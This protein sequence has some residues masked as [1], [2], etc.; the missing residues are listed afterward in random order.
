MLGTIL[1]PG[2]SGSTAHLPSGAHVSVEKKGDGVMRALSKEQVTR[3]EQAEKARKERSSQGKD[4]RA[5]RSEL[6]SRGSQE[7]I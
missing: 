5:G 7:A 1:R 3:E 2:D 4:Q 6:Q